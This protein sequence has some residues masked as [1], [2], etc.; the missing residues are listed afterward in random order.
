MYEI[1]EAFNSIT[2]KPLSDKEIKRAL[3]KAKAQP[4]DKVSL[5]KA[6]WDKEDKKDESVNEG[7]TGTVI[8][9]AEEGGILVSVDGKPVG[10]AP[11]PKHLAQMLGKMGV[12]ASTP[13]FHSSDVDFA[14]EEGF[15]SDDGAHEFIDSALEMVGL[16]ESSCKRMNEADVEENA[17]NQAAAAAARAGKDSFEFGGKTHKTTMDKSTAH[18]LD[19]DVV[20]ESASDDMREEIFDFAEEIQR[21]MHSYDNVVDELND[22]FDRVMAHRTDKVLMN[23]FKTLR[24]IEADDCQ[25]DEDGFKECNKIAQDAMDIIRG[26]NDDDMFEDSVEERKLTGGEKHRMKDL[27]KKIDKKDFIERYGKEKGESV[28]Y[29]T[30]TKMAKKDS[31]KAKRKKADENTT[32]G[33]VAASASTDSANPYGNPSIYESAYNKKIDSV[34]SE[35]MNVSMSSSTDGGDSLTVTATDEDAHALARLLKMAGL[36][37][38]AS[39]GCGCGATPCECGVM[40]EDL[41]NSPDPQYSDTDTMVNTLSGGL[42]GKKTTGQTTGAPVNRDARRGSLGDMAESIEKELHDQ[43]W[44]NYSQYKK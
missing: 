24:Q 30:V 42:N 22:M 7:E 35:G 21:G 6:P 39:T 43:L 36:P 14:S 25:E 19:D 1:F 37:A 8:F 12:D 3:D 13:M 40:E 31:A 41:A 33:S 38:P 27:E 34:L 20:A 29:A 4:K 11:T 9:N 32:S 28:Y 16:S 26:Q 15:D 23:A 10:W 17:F 2:E 18:K 44:E 5:A